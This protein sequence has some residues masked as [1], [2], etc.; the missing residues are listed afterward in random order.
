MYQIKVLKA[1]LGSMLPLEAIAN[2]RSDVRA[3]M[4][5]WLLFFT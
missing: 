2:E 3:N 1:M 4:Y 5:T